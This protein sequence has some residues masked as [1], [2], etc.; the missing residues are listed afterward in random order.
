MI[1][2]LFCFTFVSCT[3]QRRTK[4]G[5]WS[6]LTDNGFTWQEAAEY[7]ENLEEDGFSNWRLPTK[8]ELF[9]TFK[10]NDFGSRFGETDVL[11]SSTESN[12]RAEL[13]VAVNFTAN[14]EAEFPKE[15]KLRVRCIR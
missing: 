13:S 1:F 8:Y 10:R 11:W 14:Q 9:E 5:F 2:L 3:Q 7:C 6:L 12:V 4:S 15:N